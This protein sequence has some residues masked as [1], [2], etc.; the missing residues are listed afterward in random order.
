M[1]QP[2]IIH[3]SSLVASLPP[4]KQQVF[5]RIFRVSQAT[6]YLEHPKAMHPWVKKQFGSLETVTHQE[7]VKVNNLVTCEGAL[8]NRLRASRPIDIRARLRAEALALDEMKDDPLNDP[9][10]MTPEDPFGRVRGKYSITAANIAKYD[11]H[12]AIIIF[13][14]H[15]PLGFDRERIVDYIQTAWHWAQRAHKYDPEARYFFFIWNCLWK[16]GASLPHGHA[17]AMLSRESHYAKV[18]GLRRAALAYRKETGA[19]YFDDLFQAHEMVGCGFS[20]DGVRV[21]SCL[22][23]IK[24]KEVMFL[25]PELNLNLENALYDALACFRDCMNV[26]SFNV[27]LAT[28]PLSLDLEE[29]WGGFP[30][31][32]RLVDRGDPT[33]NTCDMGAMELYGSSVVASDPLEVARIMRQCLGC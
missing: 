3:L 8:F 6:G 9:E 32:A 15:N 28:P 13:D 29:D 16:A 20:R 33:T 5:S 4:E 11:A 31:L 17:Q 12:H 7:I 10:Q 21:M 23:P 26:A 22:T 19:N 27:A 18:E 30:T 2:S 14:Q 25:A 24:E 1:E